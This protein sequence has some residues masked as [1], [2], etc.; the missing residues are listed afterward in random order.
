LSSFVRTVTVGFGF[1]PNLLTLMLSHQALVGSLCKKEYHRWGVSPRP[2]D[3]N[4]VIE[5]DYRESDSE[6]QAVDACFASHSDEKL[7]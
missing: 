4:S 3:I 7:S 1:K 2:E 6:N 5:P